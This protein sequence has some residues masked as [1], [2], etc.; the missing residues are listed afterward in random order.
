MRI[1]PLHY[2]SE[3]QIKLLARDEGVSVPQLLARYERLRVKPSGAKPSKKAPSKVRRT[4]V[5]M[6]PEQAAGLAKG[7]SLMAEAAGEYH[8]GKYDSMPEALSGVAAERR[9][10][11][12]GR[13]R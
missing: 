13:Y 4:A 12:Y 5:R 11:P 9:S 10:N 6:N 2:L 8:K 7:Q 1:N 3:R